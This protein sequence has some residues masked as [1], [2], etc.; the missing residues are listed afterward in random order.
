MLGPHLIVALVFQRFEWLC[1]AVTLYREPSSTQKQALGRPAVQWERAFDGE[2]ID[3]PGQSS[4]RCPETEQLHQKTPK[5]RR[6][7][8][9]L[10]I[11]KSA[12]TI[13]SQIIVDLS[14]SF[15]F[16]CFFVLVFVDL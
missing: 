13:V 15:L 1:I 14:F 7:G 5:Q 6:R 9:L 10:E 2:S 4:R 12:L 3:W 8:R 16:V 11:F